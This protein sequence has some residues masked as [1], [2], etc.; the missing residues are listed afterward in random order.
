MVY[1]FNGTLIYI[2]IFLYVVLCLLFKF[3]GKKTITYIGFFTLFYIYLYFVIDKT[4]FPIY[5]DDTQR[6]VMG[7][8][9]VWREMNLV[10][11][12]HGFN[13]TSV[14]NIVLTIPLGVAIPFLIKPSF[15]KVLIIGLITGI[16]LELG[17]L[18]S[19]LYAGY[20]FRL[21]DIDDVIMNLLG[22]ITGYL[23]IFKSFKLLYNFLK[24]KLSISPDGNP[25][26]LHIER[27]I[28]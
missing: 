8:Q 15:L 10:P 19:A 21:V 18:T 24:E 9:N 12:S 2:Y 27:S 25:I 13:I 23:I 22:T 17:Q 28:N 7:G 5:I 20:T 14:L 3:I 4:Q 16:L 1:F 11:F 26:L 6:E